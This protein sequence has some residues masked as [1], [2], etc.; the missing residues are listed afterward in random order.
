MVFFFFFVVLVDVESWVLVKEWV[1]DFIG[2][3]VLDFIG[4]IVF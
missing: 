2:F 3:I 1:L 4:F